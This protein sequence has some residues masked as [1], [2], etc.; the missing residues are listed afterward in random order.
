MRTI[1]SFVVLT[2]GLALGVSACSSTQPDA[3]PT[4]TSRASTSATPTPTRTTTSPTPSPTPEYFSYHF[5]FDPIERDQSGDKPPIWAGD[6]VISHD[7]R[8]DD[9]SEEN[10]HVEHIFAWYPGA[11]D[12]MECTVALAESDREWIGETSVTATR[13]ADPTIVIGFGVVEDSAGLT[14]AKNHSYVQTIDMHTCTLGQRIEIVE[15]EEVTKGADAGVYIQGLHDDMVL[16]SW[17]RNKEEKTDSSAATLTMARVGVDVERGE[18]AWQGGEIGNPQWEKYKPTDLRCELDLFY[19]TNEDL[20][21]ASCGFWH[22]E[23]ETSKW[24]THFI[25]PLTGKDKYVLNHAL[26][27]SAGTHADLIGD[28]VV[29]HLYENREG[30][31]FDDWTITEVVDHGKAKKIDDFTVQVLGT[32]IDTQDGD[33]VAIAERYPWKKDGQNSDIST[34]GYLTSDGTYHE[35]LTDEQID[36]LEIRVRGGTEDRI[37]VTTTSEIVAVGFD[38]E[39]IGSSIDREQF[40]QPQDT[41]YIDGNVWTLWRQFDPLDG[42]DGRYAHSYAVTINDDLPF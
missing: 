33:K 30:G 34:F 20:L 11:D 7:H 41:R 26:G 15:P 22:S 19:G 1:P 6:A 32:P 9:S 36:N 17:V 21:T 38:G 2:V 29:I 42:F 14:P 4:P 37:F 16:A 28:D 8:L 5:D 3:K 13:G 25:D 35:V 40:Y 24:Q 23:T 27:D 39:Q 12:L 18:V 10:R 31:V